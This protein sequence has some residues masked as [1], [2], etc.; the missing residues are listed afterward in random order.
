VNTQQVVIRNT[1]KPDVESIIA[2]SKLVYP[3]VA[4]W[5]PEQLLSHLDVFSDGQLVAVLDD[6]IVGMAASL[7]VSWDDYHVADD[8][9]DFTAAGTFTNHD[10]ANGRTLYGAEVMVHP[11]R[12][13]QGIGT[14]LY[15]ARETL[16]RSLSWR[17][18]DLRR[19][20]V[21][22]AAS[23]VPGARGRRRLPE[24]RS[25]KPRVRGSDR[26]AEPRRVVTPRLTSAGTVALTLHPSTLI[27]RGRSA[28]ATVPRDA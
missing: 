2:L 23:R 20:A 6:E 11:E 5:K 10:P 7:I 14:A 17:R 22:P 4:P 26:M 25:R 18:L 12:Q 16:C 13:G 24:E 28:N 9:T 1:R 21:V 15:A 3:T 19:N 27:D 8:W